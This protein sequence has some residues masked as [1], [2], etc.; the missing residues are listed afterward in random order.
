MEQ[1][2]PKARLSLIKKDVSKLYPDF[3]KKFVEQLEAD[4]TQSFKYKDASL[5]IFKL[6]KDPRFKNLT[7]V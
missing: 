3:G 1:E 6:L 5:Y 4:L 2:I 7:L